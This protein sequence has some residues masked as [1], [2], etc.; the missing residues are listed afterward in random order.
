MNYKEYYI[1]IRIGGL[2]HKTYKLT[3]TKIHNNNS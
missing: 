1:I 3:N 2:N